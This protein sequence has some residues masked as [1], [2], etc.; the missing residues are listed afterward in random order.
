MAP[1]NE[2]PAEPAGTTTAW[3]V[4]LVDDDPA[5]LALMSL[6]VGRETLDGVGVEILKASSAAEARRLLTARTDIAVAVIDVIMETESAGLDLVR[7]LAESPAHAATRRVLHTGQPGEGR[8]EQVTR[9]ADIHDY[10]A[11]GTLRAPELR[12]RLLFQLRQHRDLKRALNQAPT[13]LRSLAYRSRYVGADFDADAERIA[14]TARERNAGLG[15]TGALVP[16]EGR[17]FQVI[18]GPPDAIEALYA[19]IASDPRHDELRVLVDRPAS[20]R[21]LPQ[22]SMRLVRPTREHRVAGVDFD[23]VLDAYARDFR[24]DPEDALELVEALGA[25]PGPALEAP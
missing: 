19:R 11:K 12:R 17:F 4:L 15:V 21:V 22:W 8:E 13:M 25:L 14:A 23:A 20:R 18:E 9:A 2:R 10:W 7:W 3:P 16:Y 24:F 5:I 1:A 6:V